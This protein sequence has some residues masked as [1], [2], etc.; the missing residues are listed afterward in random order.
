[1]CPEPSDAIVGVIA[2]DGASFASGVAFRF[3]P[4]FPLAPLFGFPVAAAL[5]GG[6][7]GS[8]S[9]VASFR[10][11]LVFGWATCN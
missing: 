9:P 7:G 3:A 2:S 10:G 6:G 4:F 5:A 1:M 11:S 8:F